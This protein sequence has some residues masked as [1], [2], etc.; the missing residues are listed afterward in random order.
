LVAEAPRPSPDRPASA[1]VTLILLAAG[2]AI[3]LGVVYLFFVR[4]A[5]GQTVDGNNLVADRV[6][7][8]RLQH[9]FT[10]L[11]DLIS[12]ASAAVVT[13]GLVLFA[14]ARRQR[15]LAFAAVFLVL[16]ASVTTEV[17]K[18]TLDRPPLI[19]PGALGYL[20][21]GNTLPSGHVTIAL[22]MA[23]GLTLVLPAPWRLPGA[24]LG[25]VLASCVALAVV[26]NG[27][28]HPSDVIAGGLVVSGWSALTL[29][30]LSFAGPSQVHARGDRR[31]PAWRRDSRLA[32]LAP[33]VAVI[34]V[35]ILAPG[36]IATGW[37][38]ERAGS[39]GNA[40]VFARSSPDAEIAC[41]SGLLLA[42]GCLWLLAGIVLSR[43]ADEPS[44][45]A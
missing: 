44:R 19:A 38:A 5:L 24:L 13:G 16:G 28:H 27:W 36:L 45:L 1:N 35:A 34:G 39:V 7:S 41:A 15:S 42:L 10:R 2:S 17:L 12:P 3:G 33:M 37:L 31:S 4:T 11:L 43:L 14:W 20:A 9:D 21:P 25:L 18:A 22:S 6:L 26:A 8:A 23:V 40:A 29:L 32:A 30:V